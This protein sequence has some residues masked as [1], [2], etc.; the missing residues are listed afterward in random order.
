VARLAL[1]RATP[2]SDSLSQRRLVQSPSL[3]LFDP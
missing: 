3:S 1:R 2:R